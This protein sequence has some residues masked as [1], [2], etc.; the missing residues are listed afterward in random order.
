MLANTIS[1]DDISWECAQAL[2]TSY[3]AYKHSQPHCPHENASS[4]YWQ[5]TEPNL[6]VTLTQDLRITLTLQYCNPGAKNNLNPNP[7][8]TPN[9][10]A[11]HYR[12]GFHGTPLDNHEKRKLAAWECK[13]I[14]MAKNETYINGIHGLS[15]NLKLHRR[16]SDVV[17]MQ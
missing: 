8:A 16:V 9:L 6:T 5:K 13:C 11:A 12:R 2:L 1:R 4:L 14:L 7:N 15:C 3:A 10:D 17:E